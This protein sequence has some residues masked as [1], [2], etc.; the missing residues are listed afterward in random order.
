M[1]ISELSHVVYFAY[2]HNAD[3]SEM[4]RR[5]PSAELLGKGL[6]KNF[7][8][9]LKH[10]A[11]I[12]NKEDTECY[13]VVWKISQHDL[14]DLDGDEGFHIHYNRIPVEIE[15]DGEK[16]RAMTY[17]MDPGYKASGLQK[18]KYVNMISKGYKENNIPLGQ[19]EQA[20]EECLARK[21]SS[22]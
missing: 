19:L 6:L 21:K 2:G 9:V 12:E 15:L 13:G 5:C 16:I 10:Y 14:K 1:R 18:Q 17:I 22:R 4:A 3:N 7:K 11:D 20:I 8:L